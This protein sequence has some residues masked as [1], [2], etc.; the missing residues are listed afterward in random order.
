MEKHFMVV[1]NLLV[2]I[3]GG[4]L[5]QVGVAA[6]IGTLLLQPLCQ[7]KVSRGVQSGPKSGEAQYV[8]S[9]STTW[10]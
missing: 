1:I 6:L 9:L 5:Q 7:S 2:G 3:N 4:V 10:V 8:G